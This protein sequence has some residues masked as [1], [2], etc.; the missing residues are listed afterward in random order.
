VNRIL[1]TTTSTSQ[2]QSSLNNNVMS[3]DTLHRTLVA[4]RTH[5]TEIKYRTIDRNNINYIK[6]I[7]NVP[8]AEELLLVMNYRLLLKDNVLQLDYQF[9]DDALLYLGISALEMA[10]T[11]QEYIIGKKLYNFQ[12]DMIRIGSTSS[13]NSVTMTEN[14]TYIRLNYMS[15]CPREPKGG[16]TRIDVYL[17]N[18]TNENECS[19]DT[20]GLHVHR[21]FDG[22]DT[23][24]DVLNWLGGCY[25]SEL[26]DKLKGGVVGD[27]SSEGRGVWCLCDLN[28]VLSPTPFDV[29]KHQRKT[30]QYLGLFPSG[31]LGIRLSDDS[32]KDGGNEL[33]SNI[34]SSARGLGAASRSMLY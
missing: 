9:V 34:S 3:I 6:Y 13:S 28:T 19:N 8:G 15:K 23:L 12:K 29:V 33:D 21:R 2:Q 5:P 30:L 20:T 27:S 4:V 11:R 17:G 31:K 16:G 1:I 25:G 26:L 10:R 18:S 22:D 14:E 32:W 7:K 24:E